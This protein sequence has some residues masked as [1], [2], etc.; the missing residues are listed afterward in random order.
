MKLLIA[1][2]ALMAAAVFSELARG[3]VEKKEEP[4][5]PDLVPFPPDDDEKLEGVLKL[6]AEGKNL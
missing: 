6:D 4:F 3:R 2:L 5:V 1:I